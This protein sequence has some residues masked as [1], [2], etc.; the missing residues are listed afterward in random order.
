MLYLSVHFFYF[1]DRFAADFPQV[2][3]QILTGPSVRYLEDQA[4]VRELFSL[5]LLSLPLFSV[6]EP[7]VKLFLRVTCF[8]DQIFEIN[9][10]PVALVHVVVLNQN[11]YDLLALSALCEGRY[12]LS[13]ACCSLFNQLVPQAIVVRAL[14]V[15]NI[16][17]H[18]GDLRVGGERVRKVVER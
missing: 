9:F 18:L 8:L 16:G 1:E 17:V 14:R 15:V 12:L 2:R 7:L 11:L 13:W 4:G 10:V 5:H 3:R 6:P